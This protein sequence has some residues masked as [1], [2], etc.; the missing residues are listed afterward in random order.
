MS[1]AITSPAPTTAKSTAPAETSLRSVYLR[2][3]CVPMIW[4]AT[5]I[6]GRIIA[7][8]LPSATAAFLRF[9]FAVL[10]LLLVLHLTQGLSTL[11]RITKR[12]LV[13]TMALGATGIFAYNL[14][15]FGALAVLPAGRTSLIV[16]LNPVVTLLVAALFLGE[17][18]SPLRWLGVALALLGVWV[19]VTRGDLSQLLQSVGRG[20]LSMLG[21]VCAWA[22]YTLLGRKLLQGLSPLLAT[23]WAALWGMLFLGL[24][25]LGD[26]NTL[27]ADQFTGQVWL[28]LAFLGV[29]G[30]AV[31]F[32]WYYEGVSRLGAARTVVFNNLVPVFGVLLAWLIL[33][34]PLSLSLMI[35]GA[36]AVTGVFMV[37]RV[38]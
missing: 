6:A 5:F 11:A 28:A 4:G 35:G 2:L 10:T 9:V 8:H 31:A 25:A 24:L 18:L 3:C 23:L 33:N 12:Q 27:H 26:I 16:A 20:E 7:A 13:G 1:T 30:T 36:M 29:L 32:V 15:F 14:L 34:E 37:N 17:R 21:A 19:V 38:K 22:A